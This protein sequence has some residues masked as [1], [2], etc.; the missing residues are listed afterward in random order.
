[1][2]R[3]HQPSTIRSTKDNPARSIV[4][5]KFK[6]VYSEYRDTCGDKL[7]L[8]LKEATTTTNKDG[9]ECLD[10]VKLAAIAKANGV[11]MRPYSHLNNG[12]K[13][14][15][16]GNRLRGLLEAGKKV[17]IDGRTFTGVNKVAA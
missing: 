12:Q 13:R 1:M 16:V 5:N 17:Q 3:K 8:A 7:A 11:P 4:P 15:S 2:K 10:L 6:A 14:M 9:R